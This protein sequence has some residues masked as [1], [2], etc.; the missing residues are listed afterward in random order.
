MTAL[1]LAALAVLFAF[2]IY[3]GALTARRAGNPAHFLD[4]G[5]RLP[6]WTLIFAAPGI[7]LGSLGLNDHFRLTA[8]YGLQYSHVALGLT[9]AGLCGALV[10]K[11]LW[12]AARQSG[13][14]SPIAL[15]GAY[16]GSTALRLILLA[17]TV[18]FAVP[19]AALSLSLAGELIAA[20]TAGALGRQQAIL[21]LA[22]FLFL[23]SA[24]GG[25]RGVIYVVAA[26]SLLLIVLLLFTGLFMASAFDNLAVWSAKAANG[27][28]TDQIPGVLHYSAG[29]GKDV[30]LGGI[31][32]TLGIVSFSL[33]LIGIVLS[34]AMGFLAVTVETRTGFAFH[35]VWMVAGLITGALLI[36]API[37]GAEVA[38]SD[39]AGLTAGAPSY[40][41]LIERF[42]SLDQFAA[43]CFVLMLLG[44][45]QVVVAFFAAAG[46]NLLTIDLVDR[47]VLPDLGSEGRRLAARITLAVL[48]AI[49]VLAAAFAPLTIAILASVALPLAA[50]LLPAFVGLCWAPFIS[51][52][53]VLTG[54]L[55]G[56]LLV[57]L[58]EPP[59]LIAFEGLF[60]DLPW[61]RWPLTIHSAAWGLVFNFA[62]C[63]IVSLF[64]RSGPER[65]H[66]EILHQA[67]RDSLRV[68]VGGSAMGNA[69]WSLT[70]IWTFLAL[71]PGAILGNSFFSKPMFADTEAKLGVPS[72]WVW[73]IVFWFIGVLLVWW[74]AYAGRMSV[75]SSDVSRRIDLNPPSG[76]LERRRAPAWIA[77]LLAR[78]AAR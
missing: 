56:G 25:W 19:F 36:V 57:I 38:A 6:P 46:A 39:P 5:N 11:R 18:I 2:A 1:L 60:L 8:V 71:G 67:F 62:A 40:T 20:A 52:R 14:G 77:L 16:Y 43:V 65:S 37:I 31:W 32:T 59:G 9:L 72:V 50:Q 30:P 74:L 51:R 73:Q 75:I 3:L 24:L 61:G 13:F 17:L 48:Y 55:F 53:A 66:R 35:Q 44:S 34:P 27:V 22:V 64:T 23:F 47:Y 78:V 69:K 26:Q 7:L 12:F 4:A 42:A 29:I 58:T 45:A 21:V 70:L 33:S 10:H 54:L 68:D 28:L 15:L 63:L 41:G 76:P 49:M